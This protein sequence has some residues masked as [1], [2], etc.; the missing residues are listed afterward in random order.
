MTY[1]VF[2]G[3]LNPTQSIN[4]SQARDIRTAVTTGRVSR[5]PSERKFDLR[6]HRHAML[7]RSTARSDWQCVAETAAGR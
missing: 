7:F 4:Q 6:K 2:I 5:G 1:N 3:T